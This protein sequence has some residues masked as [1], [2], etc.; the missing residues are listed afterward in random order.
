MMWKRF[1][2]ILVVVCGLVALSHRVLYAEQQPPV[3]KVAPNIPIVQGECKVH[4]GGWCTA[5]G[6]NCVGMCGLDGSG[7]KC[8]YSFLE[9][10]QLF[11]MACCLCTQHSPSPQPEGK[12]CASDKQCK[13]NEICKAAE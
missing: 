11:M 4:I 9:G 10:P 1:G 3:L 5:S 8:K 6:E 12:S 13:S 7:W 2:S